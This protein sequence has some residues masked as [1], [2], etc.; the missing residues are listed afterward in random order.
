MA[1]LQRTQVSAPQQMQPGANPAFAA[2]KNMAQPQAQPTDNPFTAAKTD[3]TQT[4]G[5]AAQQNA[6]GAQGQALTTQVGLNALSGMAQ[7]NA[8]NAAR[9][10]LA[11]GG[12]SYLSGQRSALV[13]GLNTFNQNQLGFTQN[14]QGVLQGQAGIASN[15]ASQNAANQQATGQANTQYGIDKQKTQQDTKSSYY[16]N[17]LADI[18]NRAKEQSNIYGKDQ[19]GALQGQYIQTKDAYNKAVSEG[20]WAAADQYLAQ[21]NSMVPA[22][23]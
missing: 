4:N 1:P 11:S 23:K 22:R 2:L 10:G 18:D 15:A 13:G 17:A 7:R 20:N 16:G 14:Q 19:K 12:A 8:S 3:Q 6:L 5:I 9:M 21:L